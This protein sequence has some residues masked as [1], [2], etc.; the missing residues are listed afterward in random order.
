MK[1]PT[2]LFEVTESLQ[3]EM[4][5]DARQRNKL[6]GEIGFDQAFRSN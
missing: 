6:L 1:G 5:D 2:K 3:G 4:F